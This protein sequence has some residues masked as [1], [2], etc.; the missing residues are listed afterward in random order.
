MGYRLD[1]RDMASALNNIYD[2]VIAKGANLFSEEEFE[3]FKRAA[4]FYLK[5]NQA[6]QQLIAYIA[7]F[8]SVAM[9]TESSVGLMFTLSEEFPSINQAETASEILNNLNLYQMLQMQYQILLANNPELSLQESPLKFDQIVTLST[10]AEQ[11]QLAEWM[12][13]ERPDGGYEKIKDIQRAFD[14]FF[15]PQRLK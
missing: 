13:S 15:A 2:Q 9:D 5:A 10:N 7:K 12:L 8:T 4:D 11:Q 3:Q 14:L 1:Y 6:D